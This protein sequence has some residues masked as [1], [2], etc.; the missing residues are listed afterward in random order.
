MTARHYC[1]TI[2]IKDANSNL[3]RR[4]ERERRLDGHGGERGRSI[5]IKGSRWKRYIRTLGEDERVRFV[6]G[7]REQCPNTGRHHVQGYIQF[8]H[9]QRGVTISTIIG[10]EGKHMRFE[11]AYGSCEDNI[12]Y[13]TKE[14]SQVEQ[15]VQFGEPSFTQGERTDLNEVASFIKDG[16]SLTEV[17]KQFPSAFIKYH[18]G[19]EKL[20]Q[21]TTP[22]N[23]S[24][25]E[26]E[27]HVRWGKSRE[28]KTTW[29]YSHAQQEGGFYRAPVIKAG[30]CWIDGYEGQK[31]VLF[32][33]YGGEGGQFSLTTLL[34][35]LDHWECTLHTKGSFRNFGPNRIII[36]SNIDPRRWYAN[37]DG[38]QV[39]ALFKRFTSCIQVGTSI[40]GEQAQ[41]TTNSSNTIE[42]KGD[43]YRRLGL[44]RV[45][46]TD[47]KVV[48]NLLK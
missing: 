3:R 16:H 45:P 27:V 40:D 34:R 25:I 19:F 33:D 1:F 12:K 24:R 6:I 44:V 14:D 2:W 28:G 42:D 8:K 36:T 5:G 46:K 48:Q 21:L 9:P 43:Q 17:A 29:A 23:F 18:R 13:C 10:L 11:R 7:Q 20:V 4:D 35:I 37:S 22:Q 32:D 39:E 30:E 38:E 15:A 47:S 31:T 41:Q 26:K